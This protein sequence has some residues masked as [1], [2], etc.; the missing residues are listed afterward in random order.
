MVSSGSCTGQN[1]QLP[2]NSR[3]ALPKLPIWK[4]INKLLWILE[5]RVVK[6]IYPG[7]RVREANN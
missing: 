2:P 5:L 7:E 3:E 4:R 1:P 6:R